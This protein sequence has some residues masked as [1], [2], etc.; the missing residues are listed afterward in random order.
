MDEWLVTEISLSGIA[1]FILRGISIFLCAAP[2]FP[3]SHFSFLSSH[4]REAFKRTHGS[5]PHGLTLVK[6]CFR[7]CLDIF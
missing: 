7:A 4:S 2:Q 3:I 5:A 6:I 1:L